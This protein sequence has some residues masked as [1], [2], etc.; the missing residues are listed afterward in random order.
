MSWT[1]KLVNG[2]LRVSANARRSERT[3][4]YLMVILV[5]AVLRCV[6]GLR[7]SLMTILANWVVDSVLFVWEAGRMMVL[8]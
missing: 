5:L 4:V 6:L 3:V 1:I 8:V 2:S 7:L